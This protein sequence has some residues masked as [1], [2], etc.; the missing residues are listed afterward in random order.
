[1]AIDKNG[2]EIQEGDEIIVRAKVLQVTDA[3]DKSILHVAWDH[4]T[5]FIDYVL[6]DAV[7]VFA[8]SGE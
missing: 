5:A 2:R 4:P 1:M 6:A 8:K 3:G 7:E